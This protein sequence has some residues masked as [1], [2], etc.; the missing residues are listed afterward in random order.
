MNMEATV[1]NGVNIFQ[2]L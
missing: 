2:S 1:N